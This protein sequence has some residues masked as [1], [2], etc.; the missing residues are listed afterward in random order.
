MPTDI[1][2]P[3]EVV[4]FSAWPAMLPYEC[5]KELQ[6]NLLNF[7]NTFCSIL[8]VSHR[9]KE[10]MELNTE[11]QDLFREVLNIP[12]N[13]RILFAHGGASTQF[14][15]I[16][17]NF[18]GKQWYVITGDFSERAYKEAQK[19]SESFVWKREVYEIASGKESNFSQIP[20][21]EIISEWIQKD[22]TYVHITDN[23][24]LFGSTLFQLPETD[25]PIIADMTSSLLSR[26]IDVSKYG[27]IYAGF[28]KN[29]APA[30]T[31]VVIIRDDLYEKLEEKLPAMYSYK[32]LVDIDS[33][34]NTPS[35]FNVYFSN[36]VLKWIKQL[37]WLEVVE[38]LSRTKS[39]LLYDIVDRSNGFY[40]NAIHE[41]NRSITNVVFTLGDWGLEEKF[42]EEASE[43][44]LVS[45]KGHKKVGGIRASIYISMSYEHVKRLANFMEKF[46]KENS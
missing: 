37:W 21:L 45:L 14:A 29:I 6:E 24:T 5:L 8:E 7:K 33:L 40:N 34:Y 15:N 25:V 17:A 12:G 27:M 31:A 35:T 4:N 32:T 11:T 39:E 38:K 44:W 20:S 2:D 30:G 43:H 41:N 23:N 16:A 3:R 1:Y 19:V 22:S 46:Q 9:S 26:E 18:Q 36:L 10:Y 42:L 28:Q 13:Y